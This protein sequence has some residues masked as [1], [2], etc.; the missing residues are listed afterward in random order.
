MIENAKDSP[1]PTCRGARTAAQSCRDVNLWR[2]V[3]ALSVAALIH[4]HVAHDGHGLPWP[5]REDAVGTRACARPGCLRR[6]IGRVFQARNIGASALTLRERW[7]TG[8]RASRGA[9]RVRWRV[10]LMCAPQARDPMWTVGC[11]CLLSARRTRETRL[12]FHLGRCPGRR[13]KPRA[14]S[15]VMATTNRAQ[16]VRISTAIPQAQFRPWRPPSA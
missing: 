15:I 10:P 2:P 13:T 11:E 7:V 5:S 12:G 8:R 14:A 3:S 9:R 4:R 1:T 16:P 6:T